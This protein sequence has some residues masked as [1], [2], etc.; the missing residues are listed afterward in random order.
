MVAHANGR[1]RELRSDS[2][3]NYLHHVLEAFEMINPAGMAAA[4]VRRR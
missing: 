4:S 3:S 1:Q 2:N